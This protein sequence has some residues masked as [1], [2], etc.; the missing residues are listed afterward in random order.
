M[1]KQKTFKRRVRERMERTGES[2]ATAR[3]R[4]TGSD[5]ALPAGLH[6]HC[7]ALRVAL[8]DAG[9]E[10]SEEL[11]LLMAGGAGAAAMAFRYEA[12]DFT[13]FHLSGW[14]PFQ[15]DIRDA[16]RRLGLEADIHETTGAATAAKAL[17]DRL[18]GGPVQVA[19]VERA[20]LRESDPVP[21]SAPRRDTDAVR[22]SDPVGRVVEGYD[23]VAVLAIDGDEV[24][25]A[26]RSPQPVRVP[27]ER[28]AAAR[29]RI[30]RDRHRLLAI[31]A[32]EPDVAA[33]VRAG[34]ERCAAGPERPPAPGMSLEG[35][36]RWADRLY[37]GRG[38]ES[39]AR[40][41]PP[42]PHREGA[43]RATHAGIAAA[44]GGLMRPLQARGLREA[45]ALLD[46]PALGALA[47]R[48]DALGRGWTA[49]GET[50]AAADP[51]D[52]ADTLLED[53]AARVRDLYA[54]EL[55]TRE[56]LA[57]VL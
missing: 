43:L 6:P 57:A 53:L 27:L 36:K 37:G 44:G 19:W 25:I 4:L 55:S 49:L 3:A 1:T 24:V 20:A 29:G 9:I 23:A 39:W 21:D 5:A 32:G 17:R 8:A 18:A 41:F 2:Y 13:S 51:T 46:L 48:T 30:R 47:G 54:Q 31:G 11:V 33:A 52:P 56:S 7:S 28:L 38:R 35:I 22:G 34:L 12:E 42:G 14:N 16:V 45:A 10:V 26:D 40:M 15:S 50:A